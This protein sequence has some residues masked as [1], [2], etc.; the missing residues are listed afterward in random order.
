[1]G[2]RRHQRGRTPGECSRQGYIR[3][4]VGDLLDQTGSLDGVYLSGL[5]EDRGESSEDTQAV[6]IEP[7]E[8]TQTE[9][10]NDYGGDPL[11]TYRLNLSFLAR[12]EDPQIRDEMVEL[13]LNAAALGGNSL[14]SAAVPARTQIKSWPWEKP[15]APERRI[16]GRDLH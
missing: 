14:G 9:P 16:A 4:L 3:N 8:T 6:A 15:K 10:W 11:L 12:H 1:M 2:D 7:W 13:L 5:P